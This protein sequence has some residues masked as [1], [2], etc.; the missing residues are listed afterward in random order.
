MLIVCSI[1]LMIVLYPLLKPILTLFGTSSSAMKYAYS[2]MMIYLIGTLP[3]MLTLGMNPF[4]NAQGY[5]TA[6]MCSVLIGAI[7]NL[8][9]DPIFIFLFRL[10]IQG[11]CHCNCYFS[12]CFSYICVLVFKES[13]G[14][15]SKIT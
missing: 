11:A 4:I 14:I 5:S 13:F 3:S 6:G 7:M 12:M 2:Y 8:V 10:G 9:L 1:V 15:K